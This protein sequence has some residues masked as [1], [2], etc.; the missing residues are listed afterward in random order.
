MVFFCNTTSMW[1]LIFFFFEQQVKMSVN[2]YQHKPVCS[3]HVLLSV[4]SPLFSDFVHSSV[5]VGWTDWHGQPTGRKKTE[6]KK[7]STGTHTTASCTVWT[8]QKVG[9][10]VHAPTHMLWC[11][12]VLGVWPQWAKHDR[13]VVEQFYSQLQST[14]YLLRI[15]Q[16]FVR[17]MR[18][19]I[20]QEDS[21]S[22]Q[23]LILHHKLLALRT[24]K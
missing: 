9:E 1:T 12:Y 22:V 6:E 24:T 10:P 11:D 23:N 8:F 20:S 14:L 13:T 2:Q 16:A 21:R 19:L 17:A 15:N 18:N 5:N 7:P 4:F 3:Y